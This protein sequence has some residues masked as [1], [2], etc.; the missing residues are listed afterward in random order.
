MSNSKFLNKMTSYLSDFYLL[1]KFISNKAGK[2]Y[3][4]SHLQKL[5]LARRII[6][7]NKRI[8]SLT[9]WQ[10]SL[11]LVEEI[12]NVP[13]SL[14]GD[15]VECGCYN[16]ASTINLSLACALTNRRLIVCDSFEGL[17]TPKDSEKYEINA[18]SVDDY[19]LWEEGE[20]S[21]EG[22][23]DAVKKNIDKLGNIEVCKFVKGYFKDTLKDIDSDF[24]VLIFED[25][26]LESSVEDCL[27][28]LWPKLQ[29]GCKFYCHEPWS[30]HIVSLFFDEKWWKKNLNTHPPGFDGSGRGI[31]TGLG[32]SN[33]GY[34]KKFNANKIKEHGKKRIYHGTKDFS[35]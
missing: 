22:G 23:L 29:E 20:F 31:I 18:G 9:T 21:S 10:Q 5:K 33:I 12:I 6:R 11:L 28:Y 32:Y 14:K 2:E 27:R 24:I 8:Y 25:A 17:P 15:I 4:I 13:K 1:F 30:I 3:G 16:G 35:D 26:D 7:N 34:S 19:F